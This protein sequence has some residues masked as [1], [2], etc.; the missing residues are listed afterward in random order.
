MKASLPRPASMDF[1]TRSS[2]S[3]SEIDELRKTGLPGD[4]LPMIKNM[5]A[6]LGRPLRILETHSGLTG[7]IAENTRVERA[8]GEIVGFD[9]M[10]SSS[11]TASCL[12]GKP[13]IELVTRRHAARLWR[14]PCR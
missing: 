4:R 10:W 14:T 11:L 9:G 13:D 5:I 8:N 1:E 6:T 12:K 3:G 2:N 7:M